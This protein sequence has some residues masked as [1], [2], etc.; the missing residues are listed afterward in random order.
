MQKI[1]FVFFL[2]DNALVTKLLQFAQASDTEVLTVFE[3]HSLE[4][5]AFLDL[6]YSTA[7]LASLFLFVNS[8]PQFEQLSGTK[9]FPAYLSN[10]FGLSR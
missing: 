6:S 9:S 3:K 4:Q 8:L 10:S 2:S 5:K 1:F 7:F